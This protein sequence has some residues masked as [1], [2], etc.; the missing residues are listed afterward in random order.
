MG[1]GS[2]ARGAKKE[3]DLL[4]RLSGSL[5]DEEMRR[6]LACGLLALQGKGAI[7]DLAERLGGD[8]GATL[9]AALAAAGGGTRGPPRP[10]VPGSAKVLQ[11][12]ERAWDDWD[13]CVG[14]SGDEDGEYVLQEHDWEP[15]YPDTGS[16]SEALDR[17]AA[18]L[19][20]LI[21]RMIDLD[22]DFDFAGAIGETDEG[23]GAGLPEW[24]DAP[25]GWT[26]GPEATRAFL[27]WE[28]LSAGR[29]GR[30]AFDFADRVCALQ[31]S[32]ENL[33][34][35][36]AAVSGFVLELPAADGRRILEGIRSHRDAGH[37]KAALESTWGP[38]SWIHLEFAR[39]NDPALYLET[40]ARSVEKD[41]RLALPVLRDLLRKG[42][43]REAQ[44]VARKAVSARLGRPGAGWDPRE[45]LL[46]TLWWSF[47]R[48]DR[49]VF[50]DLLGA[51]ER[52]AKALGDAETAAALRLQALALRGWKESDRFLDGVRAVGKDHGAMADR[53][54]GR[55]RDRVAERSDPVSRTA[56]EDD[57]LPGPRWV[58][59]LVDAARAGPDAS[60]T[61]R[62]AIRLW[63]AEVGA[64]PDAAARDHL[65]V[66]TLDL[67][68]DGRVAARSA[69][70]HRLLVQRLE[71]HG[72]PD[73][74][75]WRRLRLRAL[76]ADEVLGDILEVWR[77]LAVRLVPDPGAP[78]GP[79]YRE[80][81]DWLA[82]ARDFDPEGCR[83]LLDR[84]RI[85]HHR[86]RSLWKTLRQQ[87]LVPDGKP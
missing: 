1:A 58:H 19:R 35:D 6:V 48:A 15:P 63:L 62:G 14:A 41:G 7:E 81:A 24:I 82:V 85:D 26:L 72:D 10:P 22:P 61:L 64:S 39:R 33:G 31:E 87:G 53:L 50:L 20:P 12:W 75:R 5:S 59:A 78:S 49:G 25:D 3:R 13:A 23:L 40:C 56:E 69:A 73:L 37:W 74:R 79:D 46:A 32:L 28:W 68:R 34:L 18:R 60:A 43:S 77:R 16:V 44:E 42:N 67:D 21:P 2:G 17:A 83:A 36:G 4:A 9:R 52:A 66:L 11:E 38:W 8:T 55:W 30:D 45:T 84:W 80:C 76:G 51:W 65:G 27:E 71:S 70:L 47:D 86:R 29:A 57:D 54:F